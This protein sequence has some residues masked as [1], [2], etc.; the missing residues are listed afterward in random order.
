MIGFLKPST[1][2]S[3]GPREECLKDLRAVHCLE[4]WQREI[5]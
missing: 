2:T 4:P 3:T 5:S 1:N